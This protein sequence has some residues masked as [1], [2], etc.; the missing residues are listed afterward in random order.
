MVKVKLK[1]RK[2]VWL[3]DATDYVAEFEKHAP[4]IERPSEDWESLLALAGE[5]GSKGGIVLQYYLDN[6]QGIIR[7]PNG[8]IRL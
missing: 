2:P 6:T 7:L 3:L 4:D 1:K 8:K 5:A